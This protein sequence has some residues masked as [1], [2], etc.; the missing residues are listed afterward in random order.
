MR[1]PTMEQLSE[2]HARLILDKQD[3][4]Q[5]LEH[6]GHYGLDSEWKAS[7]SELSA[8]D[9]HPADAG[10]D[11]FERSKDI[12]LL[13]QEE[14][15]LYRI[16]AALEA[17]Q[18][19][20]YGSCIVCK[21]PIPYERLEALPDCLYCLDHA[22]R[23][24]LNRQRPIEEETIQMP[25]GYSSEKVYTG[26]AGFDGEDAWQIVEQWGNSDSPAMSANREAADYEHIG[27]ASEENEGFVEQLESFVATDITGRHVSIIH[28]SQYKRYM[29]SNEGDHHLEQD[30]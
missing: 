29:E 9:N 6:N 18:N 19:G 25:Y 11:L 10:T 21:E 30:R 1:L 7:N 5:R 28:N 8:V 20:T 4:E 17:F 14:L 2:L 12:A 23:Q 3:I 24:D 15:H 13:E 27:S 16:D 26:W 22:P